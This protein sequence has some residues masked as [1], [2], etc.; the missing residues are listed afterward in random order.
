MS[1]HVF[2]NFVTPFGT[3]A[4]NRAETEGNITTL[5]KLLWQGETHSTVSA[6]AIRFAL[7]RRLGAAEKTNRVWD[8]ALRSNVWQDH[9][10]KGWAS[11]KGVTFVDDDLLGYMIAEAAKEDGS[12]D[13]KGSATVRRAVL[14]I[15][16]AVSLTPWAGDVTFNAASPGA[17]PSAQKKGSNP[18]PYGTEVHATRYQYGIAL[19]PD[20]L[21]DKTRAAKAIDALCNLGT[22]A[23]NHGRFLFDFSPDAVVLRVTQDPAPRL[24]YCFDTTDDGKT[25]VSPKLL[26]RLAAEDLDPKELIVGVSDLECKL[27]A[28]LKARQV[29]VYGVKKACEEAVKR[30]T[31]E[32]KIK[33]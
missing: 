28:D 32:L 14:E 7:R 29:P 18:V 25:V 1:L 8:E 27:A 30:I 9:Q 12:D 19:T 2:A 6:E 26:Q 10:F 16:R 4:N 23:G 3:A 13:G 20:R 11:E 33:G 22:V 5:Q 21:R 17:T 24:L 15:T 31:A